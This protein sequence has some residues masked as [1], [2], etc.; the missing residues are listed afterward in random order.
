MSRAWLQEGKLKEAAAALERSGSYRS[1]NPLDAGT[2]PVR[3]RCELRVLPSR[4]VAQPRARAGT[5]GRFIT[6][7]DLLDLPFPDR[8]L[9]DPD[10]PKVTHRFKRENDKI[11]VETHAGEKIYRLIVEYAFGTSDQYVTMIGRDDERTY[12]AL[13]L[14]SYHT[15]DGVAWGRTAGDVPDSNSS[16]NIRGEPINVRDGVVRCLYCHVT[17][18][19]DFR[20]PPPEAIGPA[21]ADRGNR[22]R[23]LPRPR[24][25]PREGD[26]RQLRGRRHREPRGRGVRSDR[27]A[28]CRLPHRRSRRREIKKAPEDPRSSARQD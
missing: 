20:D 24:R 1:E 23:A 25:Q 10:D 21:A 18:Y 11:K 16:E 13:R 7:R 8:P 19:R 28:L 27:Q 14:S 9:A 15:A 22:L 3:G 17:F 12:R 5:R 26:Q 4:G 6:A 2:E